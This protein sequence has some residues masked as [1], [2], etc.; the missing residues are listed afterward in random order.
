MKINNKN[1]KTIW[2]NEKDISVGIIDQTKLPH[3]LEIVSLK[4]LSDVIHA[5]NIMQ[6]RGAPLIGG[7]AAYGIF[8][9]MKD[10]PSDDNLALASKKLIESRPTAVN[11]KSSVDRMNDELKKITSKERFE[12]SLQL[13]KTICLEDEECCKLIGLHGKKI[14]EQHIQDNNL[15]TI[16]ILTHCNAGWLA[17]IDWGTATSP[18][19]HAIKDGIK[20]HV[21]VDETR[22]RNQG[23]SLTSYELTNEGIAN[24]IISDNA[25]GLLMKEGKV[26]MCITGTD[27]ILSNGDVINKIGTYLK[28]L[29]AYDNK[30]PFYVALP[31]TTIDMKNNKITSTMI[32]YRSSEELTHISGIDTKGDLKE[33]RIFPKDCNTLNPAFDITPSKLITGLITEKG[34]YDSSAS[35]LLKYQNDENKLN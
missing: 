34:V 12:A 3:S 19:Y 25:G 16:N 6:V 15:D 30:I 13:A 31:G 9:A 27:R 17:T 4:N 22:P 23:A 24:T 5:I 2:F 33:V 29:A 18:I 21:W 35:G 14:I 11:L 1:Y 32:E 10:N 7:A 8:L 28:A 26:D 20:V